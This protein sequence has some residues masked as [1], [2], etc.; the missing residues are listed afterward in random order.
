MVNLTQPTES[1]SAD[2]AWEDLLH[3]LRDELQE[4]GGLMGL[5][6]AQQES[7]LNR[8]PETLL[9]LNQ[10]VRSQMETS[11]VLQDRRNGYVRELASDFGKA[12]NSALSELLP[13]FPPVT[14]PMFES[15]VEEINS[16][17]AKI[18]RKLDQNRRLLSRLNEVTEQILAV[19]DPRAHSKTYDRRGDLARLASAAYKPTLEES[20]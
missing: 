2:F 13:C 1:V 8:E 3:L 16:L 14:R 11:Q 18:R 17:I 10:S 9:E 20:A 5:L 15:I 4:Y 19:A 7:I 12:E 6:S